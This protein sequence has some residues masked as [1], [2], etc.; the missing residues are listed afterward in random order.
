MKKILM[1]IGLFL[2]G[3][4]NVFAFEKQEV[5]LDKCVDGDTAWF[6]LDGNKI[7]A[8]F[9]AIDTPESTTKVEEYGK[10]ANERKIWRI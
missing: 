3:C 2:I 5:T 4:I 7:K 1:F 10:E 9:L 8:R 6:I